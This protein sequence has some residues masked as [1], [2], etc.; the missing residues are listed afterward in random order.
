MVSQ[1]TIRVY[2]FYI[3]LPFSDTNGDWKHAIS[4]SVITG[5]DGE[6]T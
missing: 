4:P 3:S 5:V 6:M 1:C 2:I